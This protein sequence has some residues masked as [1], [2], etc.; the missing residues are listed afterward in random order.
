LFVRAF[1][2][3]DRDDLKA[4]L[5]AALLGTVWER[6]PDGA[7]TDGPMLFGAPIPPSVVLEIDAS[8]RISIGRELDTQLTGVSER[9]AVKRLQTGRKHVQR[10]NIGWDPRAPGQLRARLIERGRRLGY[11]VNEYKLR[12]P[13]V[14]RVT[15]GNRITID[16]STTADTDAVRRH[17]ELRDDDHRLDI[18]A[19]SGGSQATLKRLQAAAQ[20]AGW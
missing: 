13:I 9:E 1:H 16:A 8:G 15:A 6:P 12:I 17:R 2:R 14:V 5:R 3:A 10:L 18:A 11:E 7:G 19:E 4:L 20:R